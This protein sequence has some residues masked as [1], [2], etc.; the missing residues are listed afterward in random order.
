MEEL[1]E[2][3]Q[4]NVIRLEDNV[5]DIKVLHNPALLETYKVIE[6]E[7]E[8]INDLYYY[9]G[10]GNPLLIIPPEYTYMVIQSIHAI[11]HYGR[12]RTYNLVHKDYWWPRMRP[13]IDEYV[14][15]CVSCQQ[16]KKSPRLKRQYIK[17]QQTDRF[18]TLHVDIVGPL[19]RTRTGYEYIFTMID[20][21]SRWM[22][23][24]PMRR[25]TAENCASI[26]VDTWISRYGVPTTIISDQG[27]QF[28]SSI[29]REI[30]KL[31]GIEK[32]RTTAYHPQSNGILERQHATIKATLRCLGA[33]KYDWEQWLPM[34]LFAMRNA[35]TDEQLSPAMIV[36]GEAPQLPSVLLMKKES[37][38]NIEHVV[39]DLHDKCQEIRSRILAVDDTLKHNETVQASIQHWKQVWVA[40]PFHVDALSPKYQG[41]FVILERKYPV[42]TIDRWGQPVKVNIDRCK[43]AFGITENPSLVEINED[44]NPEEEEQD[45][46]L[47]DQNEVDRVENIPEEEQPQGLSRYGRRRKPVERLGFEG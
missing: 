20:R 33:K 30:L 6:D 22:E 45:G 13:M 39:R 29:F 24:I 41:P 3:I 46:Q 27:T 4:N 43:P 36:F 21:F 14:R 10:D 38:N 18:A 28:E 2:H 19:P 26:I 1:H 40:T 32:R 17:F 7:V 25:I 44:E 16:N 47:V 35:V 15:K 31:L 12:R 8:V 11:G 37:N 34:T 9:I 23:A 5:D 42:L